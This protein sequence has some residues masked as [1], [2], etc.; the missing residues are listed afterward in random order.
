MDWKKLTTIQSGG[1]CGCFVVHR[2]LGAHT[3]FVVNSSIWIYSLQFRALC[4]AC[5]HLFIL[6]S[7]ILPFR[8]SLWNRIYI[9]D[10]H[11]YYAFYSFRYFSAVVATVVFRSQNAKKWMFLPLE[12]KRTKFEQLNV[13]WIEEMVGKSEADAKRNVNIVFIQC[14]MKVLLPI[15]AHTFEHIWDSGAQRII[16][17][18]PC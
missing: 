1:W 2:L 13:M 7:S 3:L 15:H 14:F 5:L 18:I 12:N 16:G 8:R 10:C 11:A 9:L 17:T 6:F 4:R